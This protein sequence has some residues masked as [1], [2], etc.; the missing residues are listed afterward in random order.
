MERWVQKAAVPFRSR[1][2]KPRELD[3]LEVI[4][5]RLA[6]TSPDDG[7]L[8]YVT[9]HGGRSDTDH[10]LLLPPSVATELDNTAFATS[11]LVQ[12]ALLGGAEHV[13]ILIDSCHG[14]FLADVVSARKLRDRPQRE[15]GS[16]PHAPW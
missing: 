14:G 13:V 15:G 4:R 5:K 16:Q 1:S 11:R 9:A 6:K 7:L 2:A 12:E 8:V 3:D 10:F